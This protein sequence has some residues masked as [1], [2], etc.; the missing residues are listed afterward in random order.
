VSPVSPLDSLLMAGVL[1]PAGKDPSKSGY[2]VVLPAHLRWLP[3][4]AL[5]DGTRVLTRRVPASRAALYGHLFR[6]LY[7]EEQTITQPELAGALT[8]EDGLT[9]HDIGR[10]LGNSEGSPLDDEDLR[11]ELPEMAHRLGLPYV[12]SGGRADTAKGLRRPRDRAEV[13]AN[14]TSLRGRAERLEARAAATRNG[15]LWLRSNRDV[16]AHRDVTAGKRRVLEVLVQELADADHALTDPDLALRFAQARVSMDDWADRGRVDEETGEPILGRPITDADLRRVIGFATR[17]IELPV[18]SGQRGYW[19]PKVSE[20]DETAAVSESR[21]ASI[22]WH[23]HAIESAAAFI[24]PETA[25]ERAVRTGAVAGG[26]VPELVAASGHY[27]AKAKAATEGRKAATENKAE[28]RGV[29][30]KF[31]QQLARKAL[32]HLDALAP[33]LLEAVRLKTASGQALRDLLEPHEYRA[34]LEWKEAHAFVKDGTPPKGDWAW[35]PVR[36]TRTAQASR[37]RAGSRPAKK[38]PPKASHWGAWR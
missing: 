7:V 5:A 1:R 18:A 28:E 19:W 4:G 26:R 36:K 33:M 31:H 34:V 17:A 16:P 30:L 6:H 29:T 27:T 24:W 23:A 2:L 38:R 12:Y 21:A 10:G 37:S 20:L 14:A 9:S 25:E 13:R 8:K 15:E 11:L 35:A 3:H 22:R 32:V